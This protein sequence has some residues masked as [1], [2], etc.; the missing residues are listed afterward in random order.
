MPETKFSQNLPSGN[1]KE[2]L[3]KKKKKIKEKKKS[4]PSFSDCK[5]FDTSSERAALVIM[6][7]L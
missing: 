7:N 3:Y 4:R 2:R 6:R 5:N 1:P